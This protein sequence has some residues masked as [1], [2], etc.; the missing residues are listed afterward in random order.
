VAP[1]PN[2][3]PQ[4]PAKEDL[5]TPDAKRR[6]RENDP[7]SVAASAVASPAGSK[8]SGQSSE[9]AVAERASEVGLVCGV[10]LE[11]MCRPATN[12]C[13]HTFCLPCLR[14]VIERAKPPRSAVCPVCRVPLPKEA[15]HLGENKILMELMHHAHPD[16]FRVGEARGAR[17]RQADSDVRS[18]F[19]AVAQRDPAAVRQVLERSA[20]HA[21]IILQGSGPASGASPHGLELR[22]NGLGPL[23][24]A[25]A[26][27]EPGVVQAMV[28]RMSLVYGAA[29]G[30]EQLTRVP[31]AP[32]GHGPPQR[33]RTLLQLHMDDP[34]VT[35]FRL[36]NK[37]YLTR[38]DFSQAARE[39]AGALRRNSRVTRLDL[40]VFGADANLD[41]LMS[42]LGENRGIRILRLTV[43]GSFGKVCCALGKNQSLRNLILRRDDMSDDLS[44]GELGMEI[45]IFRELAG[46]LKVNRKIATLEMAAALRSKYWMQAR[47]AQRKSLEKEI[48]AFAAALKKSVSLETISLRWDENYGEKNFEKVCN[49]LAGLPKLCNLVVESTDISEN[50][51][52][53]LAKVVSKQSNSLTSLQF[54]DVC[55]INVVGLGHIMDAV[56]ECDSL[57]LL[58]LE[59]T[60]F[61]GD[62]PP[63]LPRGS[64]TKLAASHIARM[65]A[66][67]PK[68]RYL[69]IS[70]VDYM[71][72]P[73]CFGDFELAEIFS[74]LGKGKNTHLL[75]L[76]L[77]GQ[78]ASLARGGAASGFAGNTSL[79]D[80]ALAGNRIGK[81]GAR[82]IASMLAC[83][84]NAIQ[85]LSLSENSSLGNKMCMEVLAAGVA[86]SPKLAHLNLDTVS[87]TDGGLSALLDKCVVA[88]KAKHLTR[89]AIPNNNLTFKACGLLAGALAKNTVLQGLDLRSNPHIPRGEYSW[90]GR[91]ATFTEHVRSVCGAS[92][93]AG[94]LYLRG[95]DPSR[96]VDDLGDAYLLFPEGV[97][98]GGLLIKDDWDEDPAVDPVNEF[99]GPS[100]IR[101]SAG[102]MYRSQQ[103]FEFEDEE[104]DDDYHTHYPRHM[105][106]DAGDMV[107]VPMAL[108]RVI[109]IPGGP[110]IRIER[111]PDSDPLSALNGS[112][113]HSIMALFRSP[114]GQRVHNPP[115]SSAGPYDDDYS[116]Y[117][118]DDYYDYE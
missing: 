17:S 13:G 91:T 71:E 45:M 78:Q 115:S 12:V 75:G 113:A 25:L 68:L 57:A 58:V 32:P 67:N 90:L 106:D 63:P 102:R 61:T 77:S 30:Q 108:Q 117:D 5:G 48:G 116:E 15:S 73:S 97:T 35:G 65:L 104:Y 70:R 40:D 55:R 14:E 34:G 86:A 47:P 23:V 88:N 28:G 83:K 89:L 94:R 60:S 8:R 76:C 110:S 38:A 72:R 92:L 100:A 112:L 6:R 41:V 1:V 10:C 26:S 2:P 54:K 31:T 21:S 37:S 96:L 95:A 52:K 44:A 46:L 69:V 105:E 50:M 62:V 27:G 79:V 107:P 118:D 19:E 53:Q 59:D 24:A 81:A 98:R 64:I 99:R 114:A 11:V 42:A 101:H 4:S 49:A 74:A 16:V 9:T 33:Y 36:R 66:R 111:V 43:C 109:G 18:L 22:P 7:R 84:G 87:L 82:E 29:V 85:R 56:P 3:S 51:A 39:A 93:K 80:L 103:G 20:D